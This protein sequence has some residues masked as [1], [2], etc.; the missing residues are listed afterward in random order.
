M[1]TVAATQQAFAPVLT[2]MTTMR[3]GE[4]EQKKQA[5]QFLESFQKSSEAWQMTIGILKSTADVEAKLFAATT[6]RGK[7]TY[8]AN[9]IPADALPALRDQILEL[10][11]EFAAGPRPIRIQLC[12]CLATLAIQMTGW[13]D[14]VQLVGTTLGA[15]TES[16]ACILDFLKVLP[17]E[18]TEGRKINLTEDELFQRTQELLGDNAT[19][20]VQLLINYT[21]SSESASTNPQFLEVITSWLREVPVG[22]VVNS[23]LLDI[24]FKALDSDRS[25]E[26]ATDCLCAIFKE[27]REVDEYLST[28]QVLLPRVVALR[29]RIRQAAAEGDADADLY[30]GLTRIFSDAGEAWVV[31]IAREPVA[32]RPLVEAVLECA[33]L[34]SDRDAVALTFNFWYELKLYLAVEIYIQ[35]RVQYV[36]VFSSLVDIMLKQLEFPAETPGETD[37]FD[38]DREAEEN[39]REFRHHMGDV[40]KDC[41][42][43]MGVTE[44]LSKVLDRIKTW[45]G[46]YAGQATANSVPH[47]QQ[48]EAPLFSM[49]AMGKMVDKDE[50][51]IL[52]QIMPLI[53]QIPHHEKLRFA[54]IMVLG[55]YTEWTS[56]HPELLESQFTYIVSS[57]ATDSKEIIRAAA[58]SMKYFCTDCK[59]FLS[60]QVV[61]LQQFYDQTLDSLPGISQ[62]EL[63]DGVAN[64]VAVQPPTQTFELLKLYCD[65]LM[66]RL[67]AKANAATD[68][69]GK[70]AVADHMQ[71]I[72]IFIQNVKPY[73]EPGQENPAV[74]YC[75]EIFPILSTILDTFSTFTPICERIC[76]CWRHMVLSYRTATSPLLPQMA[77][78]LASGFSTSKQ[79]CFLWA[80]SAILREFSEDREHV[81]ENTTESIYSFFE[82]QSRN[83]LQTM[84]DLPPQDLPD[85]IED[86]YRLLVDALLYYPH[87]LIGSDIFAPI[88][89]AAVAALSLQQREPLTAT[90]HYIRDVIGYGGD[91]PP[92]SSRSPNPIEIQNAVKALLVANGEH[93]VKSILA[94]MMITFP[95]DCF[96]D[97]SGA[98]L[99]LFEIL[100][101]QTAL[102][103]DK[104]V[105]LLPAGTVREAEIDRLMSGIQ[106]RLALGKDGFR[107]VRSL[108]QDFTNAYRRRYVAPRDGLGSLEA[109]RFHYQA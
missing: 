61:Q 67:M 15:S 1:A 103:V 13:K 80:T 56:N 17:E 106:E 63:T 49:R 6:L 37:L 86:F 72:T 12:V 77:N 47:W 21:Q 79:G 29:P 100:P 46:A 54:T 27:T 51:I 43:I 97:G 30:K 39:F 98:L 36:D 45:M 102:W 24:I 108:L 88:L 81:D 11:K 58:M 31:L 50:D 20:V 44:C 55:R 35:A 4:R 70:L 64:V 92:S 90:L 66:T 71:L 96:T 52:P 7:I 89:Q 95:D 99:G 73:V 2:A 28:I 41:C 85:V 33:A 8:D 60:G 40:L 93:L 3:D 68:D 9:Q 78:K 42:E 53:V 34:D 82:V 16:H 74:K 48:L 87:K 23:P 101:E 84:S 65:P 109:E 105:R 57:F 38:G 14:V 26:A 94:G 75:Q 25:F 69:E 5:H 10:L 107:K 83:M 91:N 22:D 59:H 104:T 62:E 32:F 18:V 76:R 19:L